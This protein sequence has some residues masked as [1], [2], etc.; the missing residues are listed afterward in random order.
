MSSGS[1]L[2]PLW[3]TSRP[4]SVLFDRFLFGGLEKRGGEEEEEEGRS[5]PLTFADQQTAFAQKE[6]VCIVRMGRKGSRGSTRGAF[7]YA[8][9]DPSISL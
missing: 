6:T 5:P 3:Q 7:V 8:D 1:V 9:S 2:K 4:Q